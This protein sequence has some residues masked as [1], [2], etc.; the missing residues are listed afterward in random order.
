VEL[1]GNFEWGE[2]DGFRSSQEDKHFVVG[3]A[4]EAAGD[5]GAFQDV[6]SKASTPNEVLDD[7]EGGSVDIG[8][9]LFPS[10]DGIVHKV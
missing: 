3:P 10:A 6:V 1:L 8:A 5:G 7:L 2:L 4:S 9:D